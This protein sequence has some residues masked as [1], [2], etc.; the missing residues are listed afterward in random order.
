MHHYLMPDTRNGNMSELRP[1]PSLTHPNPTRTVFIIIPFSIPWKLNFHPSPF[2]TINFLISR[3]NHVRH[4]S[5]LYHRARLRFRPPLNRVGNKFN[6]IFITIPFFSGL[7]F[8]Y[9]RL[10]AVMLYSDN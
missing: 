8:Q 3:T 1:R 6:V 9:P 4:L 5:A 10:P 2:V 7:F